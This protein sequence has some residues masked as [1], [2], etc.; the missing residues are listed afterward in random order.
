MAGGATIRDVAQ[1]AEVSLGS[2]SNYL[3]DKK[4]VSPK[5]RGRIESAIAE[6]GYIPNAAARIM[7][8]ARSHAIAFMIPDAGNP[9]LTEVARGIEDVAIRSGYVVVS[10]NTDGDRSR[11]DHYAQALSEM[12]VVG[13]VVMAMSTSESHL[14]KLE[15]SGAVVVIAG[16]GHRNSGFPTVEVDNVHGGYVAMKH[17]LERGHRKIVFFGGPGAEPQ[18][19]DRYAGCQQAI[20]E[21]G[22]DPRNLTR[23]DAHGNSTAARVTG[24]ERVA[25]IIPEVTAAVCANDLL[26]L[27]LEATLIR[28]GV[29]IPEQ[30]AI[31]GYDDID[32]AELAPIPLT[33]VRQP[34]YDLG[35]VAAQLVLDLADGNEAAVIESFVPELV[36]R[37]TT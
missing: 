35:R 27:A 37:S 30:F 22:L 9:F 12:R 29:S 2:I 26:A 7:R 21:A 17:L 11:E 33:T 34:Q 24:A 10:C 18:I 20:V 28:R 19:D 25:D 13:A 31:V 32:T 1:L 5:A 6:L 14:R 16:S 23:L 3:T 36:V 8:G 4:P 15:A